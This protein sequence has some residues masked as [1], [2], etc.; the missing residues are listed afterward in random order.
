M[1]LLDRSKKHLMLDKEGNEESNG[2][3]EN[4]Q[5]KLALVSVVLVI[6][7]DKPTF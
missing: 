1:L 3:D 2:D 7:C 5:V 4:N 6:Y